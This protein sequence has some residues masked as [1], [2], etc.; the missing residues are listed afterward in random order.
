M[1]VLFMGGY[2]REAGDPGPHSPSETSQNIS[3]L[4]N[5]GPD[6]LKI[7]KASK[8]EFNVGPS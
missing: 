3:F 8:P 7:S 2:R 1:L 5:T 4:S 6:P